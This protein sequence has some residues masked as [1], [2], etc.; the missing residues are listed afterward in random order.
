MEKR[1]SRQ[2]LLLGALVG[3]A[4]GII[5]FIPIWLRNGGQYVEY[6]DYIT[7]YVPFIQELKRM[8][9]SGNFAWSWNTFLG[10]SFIGVY[11]YYTVFNPFAWLVAAF[12]NEWIL[13]GTMFA[14]ILKMSVSM[15]TSMLYMRRFCKNNTYALIGGLLYTFSGY[16]IINTYF[17]FFLDV[18]AVFP[19]LMYG[20]ELL[21]TERKRSV[22][23]VALVL[24][25]AINYYLFVST[26][27]LVVIY[28]VFRLE[29]Y[30]ASSWKKHG[31]TFA[32]IVLCSI[33]GTGMAGF[34]L[35]PSLYSVLGSGKATET[36][37]TQMSFLYSPQTILE[38]LRT[39]VAPIESCSYHVFYNA[40]IWNSCGIYLPAV[41]SVFVVYWCVRKKDWLKKI[42]VFMLLC[43]FIP[44][45]N[46]VFSLFSSEEYTRWLY[47]MALLFSLV[48]VLGLE[49]MVLAGQRL[50]KKLVGTYLV[51]ASALLLMPTAV[52]LLHRYGEYDVNQFADL[53][54]T[55]RFM[56]Y[57]E[58]AV[59]LVLSAVNFVALLCIAASKRNREKRICWTVAV[60]CALNYGVFNEI[61]YDLHPSVY[62]NDYYYQKTLVVGYENPE[63]SYSYRID[64]PKQIMNYSLAR[65]MPSVN[66]FNSLQNPKSSRFAEAVGIADSMKDTILLTPSAGGVYTN[67]LLSVQYYYDYDGSGTIHQGFHHVATENGVD[68]YENENYI[69]MGFTYDTYCTEDQLADLLPQ[70]RAKLMLQ[71]LVVREEDADKASQYLTPGSV[72]G[73][74]TDLTETVAARRE[75]ACSF[76]E[77]TS[78]GFEA[79]ID[80]DRD[81]IV[82]FSIPNDAGWEITVNG[83]PAEIL[84]VHYGLIGICCNEG[85]NEIT[86]EYHPQGVDTGLICSVL[87][88]AAWIIWEMSL[89]RKRQQIA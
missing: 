86:A 42:C 77:G 44:V 31:K 83:E 33:I 7:Q 2:S 14:T 12:P 34:A 32:D 4:V 58:L 47:G 37:G 29:L 17:Y 70:E 63:L 74:E 1:A 51:A 20:L 35:I 10:D 89:K 82:F 39:L 88:L 68:I 15:V 84:E 23:L 28:V 81:N 9:A 62:S 19:L 80:L 24:N 52:Y 79:K 21:I 27:F 48:T 67:A 45:L 75:T 56:G 60:I 61:N 65:N 59:M 66:S 54:L 71:N 8:A 78:A 3:A 11:S 30:K 64:H 87:C 43:Y 6:G 22:Y 73:S 49:E 55:S 25:A 72:A 5:S 57:S 46:A 36:I 38:R 16:T 76:F 40:E 69:P 85:S 13:Y 53:C 50:S 41:G 18:I 26:V